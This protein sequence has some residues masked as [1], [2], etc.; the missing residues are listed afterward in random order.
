MEPA[1]LAHG[2]RPPHKPF[3]AGR[4]R[5]R[6]LRLVC[7][8]CLPPFTPYCPSLGGPDNPPRGPPALKAVHYSTIPGIDG[9]RGPAAEIDDDSAWHQSGGPS[10]WIL[11]PSI[12]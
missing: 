11:G 1:W 6:R 3:D 7:R 12:C 5:S 10:S 2:P 9:K 4:G 8:L